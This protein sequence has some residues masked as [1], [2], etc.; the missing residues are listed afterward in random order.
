MRI[1]V[2]KLLFIGSHYD[3]EKF[4]KKA[5][6]AGLV[7]FVDMTPGEQLEVPTEI[8]EIGG[9]IKVLCGLP[10]MEQ[11]E[12]TDY[13]KSDEIAR[14][15]LTLK[16]RLEALEEEK[17]VIR[18]EIARIEVFGNFSLDD[19]SV[20][21]R[22][23]NRKI[24]FFFAKKGVFEEQPLPD[25]LIYVASDHGLDYFVAVN[26]ETTYYDHMIEMQI[27]RPLGELKGRLAE[28]NQEL[29][30]QEQKLKTYAKYNEYLH[31]ALV[32]RMNAYNLHN[33]EN[34][35]EYALDERLFA[36]EGWVS[37]D[38]IT[39]IEN[40]VHDMNV[41]M[42]EIAV[43]KDDAMPTYLENSGAARIGEDLVHIYDTPS[44]TDKDPSL[45]VLGA[46]S[47]F[48]A[49]IIG[50]AGYGLIFLGVALYL[51]WKFP[52]PT[53]VAKRVLN[54][55]TI[56]C[57]ACIT[58]GVLTNSF[59]GLNI[60]PESPL[61][62]F[63]VISWL[64]EKKAAYHIAEKDKTYQEWVTEF[65][66][67][68]GVTNPQEFLK[69]GSTETNG[70][71]SYVVLSK[72][73]DNIMMELALFIGVVHICLSLLRYLGRNWAA[74]G[75]VTFIIGCYFY[76]PSYLGATSMLE[77]V[78][79]MD[80]N[81]LPFEGQCMMACG[82]GV[83]LVLSII[84]NKLF[85]LLEIV[86]VIQIFSDILSYLRLYALGLASAILAGTVNEVAGS[87]VFIVGVILA[88]IGHS[89]NMLLGIMSGVIHG[90]RLN[91]LEWYHYSFEGDGKLFA[92]LKKMDIE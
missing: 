55:A 88:I 39:I 53:K 20:I 24:Q 6:R 72:F 3:R 70:K 82:L 42:E 90:L 33:N 54:L 15:V 68:A 91:F 10:T 41:H 59:F 48:F 83:A 7:H 27:D 64:A 67:L 2:K 11:E 30:A 38:K 45:W 44:T 62:N 49:I 52:N 57:V 14:E 4:F 43:E 18:L 79:W 63:S 58:W 50:D 46:F 66:Q 23:G 26:K 35:V 92:P 87:T 81:T 31:H 71:T 13:R 32:Y 29:H 84:Q 40:L 12:M 61:R 19:I 69:K 21:E 51:R 73:S 85:G 56:L 17:R 8:E 74:I 78:F 36:V 47:L 34:F 65:P 80:R 25:G 89:V 22:Q 60:G 1:D 9:A 77:Y 75:W 76:F 86:N 5:Q 37:V 28:I 16:H